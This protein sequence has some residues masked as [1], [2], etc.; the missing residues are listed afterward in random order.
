MAPDFTATVASVLAETGTEP[1]LVT[2]EVTETVFIQDSGRAKV[3]LHGLKDL[4][5]LL[6]LDDF[7]TG[8]SSLTYL[9]SFPVDVIK[10]DQSFIADLGREPASRVIV[11]AIIGL[12]HGLGMT[13]VA[14]G[15]ESVR[16][17]EE[18][19]ALGCD[20]YQGFHFARPLSA[21][22]LATKLGDAQVSARWR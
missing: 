13:V 3:V 12:A 18:V 14:E 17:H 4:G 16:Q 6:A 20:Y 5:V 10:I 15:V 8:F 2:L 22:T 19:A 11:A 9:K 21:I 1:R 7:G